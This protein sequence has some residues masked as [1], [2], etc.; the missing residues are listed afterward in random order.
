MFLVYVLYFV[1]IAIG[2]GALL[3]VAMRWAALSEYQPTG[4]VPVSVILPLT[5]EARSF[6]TL[7][8]ALNRQ[9]LLPACL[10]VAVESEQD[11][12]YAR[13]RAEAH[14]ANFPIKL[15]VAGPATHQA[16]KCRNQQAALDCLDPEHKVIALMDGD[17]VPDP[18][19]L[20]GL[21]W[22][23]VSGQFD[24][25]SGHRW[26]QVAKHRLGAHLVTAVD[27]GLTL[28]PRIDLDSASVAWGGSIAMTTLVAQRLDLRALFDRVLS[29]DLALASRA[30][31]LGLRVGTHVSLLVP[32]PNA[33][34]LVSA[35]RFAR[36]QYQMCRIY[37]P[38]LWRFG[39][40]VVGLRLAGWSAALWFT[41]TQQAAGVWVLA[42][43]TV[44]GMLKQWGVGA[45]ARR[46]DM[47]DRWSVRVVQILLG[48]LQPVVDAFHLS[49]IVGAAWMRRVR[50]GHVTYRVRGPE[51]I[52][53]QSRQT[54]DDM[55]APTP[56]HVA[57]PPEW[58]L[59]EL[60][61]PGAQDTAVKRAAP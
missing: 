56:D 5:G 51:N 24:I 2:F 20:G 44:L 39:L 30:A 33:Q 11:P 45:V 19:W 37:R 57:N 27:R 23:I 60:A 3:I 52:E 54:F 53:I 10:L 25:I 42:L 18:E 55:R 28:L 47:P 22:P 61:R 31:A 46:A 26:Q 50:W 4:C 16:Q 6:A 36:R 1:A 13:V 59:T 41:V 29:D 14:K 58:K 12:A 21:V 48:G 8:D 38:A 7:L 40:C 32:S 9:T 35:W 49:V 43:L 17:I 34:S 15:I